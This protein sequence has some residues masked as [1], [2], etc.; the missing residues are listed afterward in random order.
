MSPYSRQTKPCN[1]C[2]L[3]YNV[4]SDS[5][6]VEVKKSKFYRRYLSYQS[7][8][9]YL[10]Y[11][12]KIKNVYIAIDGVVFLDIT[13]DTSRIHDIL[14]ALKLCLAYCILTKLVIREM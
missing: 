14:A 1:K 10:Q 12:D 8:R 4:D 6:N 9:V 11:T 5:K 2:S 7:A 3:L 13:S